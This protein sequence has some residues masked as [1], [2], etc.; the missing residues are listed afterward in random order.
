MDV[1]FCLLKFATDLKE[2]FAVMT[3]S[4][5]MPTEGREIETENILMDRQTSA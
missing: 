2:T 4:I 3:G 1:A 5:S